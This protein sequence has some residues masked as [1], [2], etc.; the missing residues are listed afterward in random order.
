[1]G[2]FDRRVQGLPSCIKRFG[3]RTDVRRVEDNAQGA[4][5]KFGVKSVSLRADKA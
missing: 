3:G 1:M 2:H 4:T 5:K